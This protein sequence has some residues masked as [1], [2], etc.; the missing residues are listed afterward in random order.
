MEVPVGGEVTK[1]ELGDN[2]ESRFQE[3]VT[4]EGWGH[5]EHEWHP[6]VSRWRFGR[7]CRSMPGPELEQ[8]QGQEETV[9]CGGQ[10]GA[11]WGVPV[12]IHPTNTV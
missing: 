4:C 7:S 8:L 6:L 10:T 12:S 11:V 3:K 9:E 5:L 2:G 1:E